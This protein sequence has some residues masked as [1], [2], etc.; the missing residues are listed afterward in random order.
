LTWQIEFT[1]APAKHL[2]E[3][4]PENGRQITGFL[5]KKIS[6]D[7]R[8]HGKVLKGALRGFWRYRVGDFRVLVRIEDQKLLVLVVRVGH[9]KNVY[10]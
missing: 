8:G 3:I 7:P 4:G 2:K 6:Q 10:R 1:T 9:R 5:R